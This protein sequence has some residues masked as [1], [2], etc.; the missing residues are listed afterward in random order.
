MTIHLL[1]IR[2]FADMY[3]SY[4]LLF[5]LL[6]LSLYNSSPSNLFHIKVE[7]TSL[8]LVRALRANWALVWLISNNIFRS[9]LWCIRSCTRDRNSRINSIF[10]L[11]AL[12]YSCKPLKVTWPLCLLIY[13]SFIDVPESPPLFIVNIVSW[14]RN[15]VQPLGIVMWNVITIM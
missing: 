6:Y 15:H 3:T 8:L 4:F 12:N 2:S 1:I 5:K 10:V 11:I 9:L 13:Y 7:T 14:I